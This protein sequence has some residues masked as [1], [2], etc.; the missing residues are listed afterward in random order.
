MASI[1]DSPDF[2]YLHVHSRKTVIYLCTRFIQVKKLQ[3]LSYK[4]NPVIKN[5]QI[6]S[7]TPALD[8]A[9]GLEW[10]AATVPMKSC[11]LFLFVSRQIL[12]HFI[13][14]EQHVTFLFFRQISK[15][16]I[17]REKIIGRVNENWV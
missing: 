12:Y 10:G 3:D 4:I 16:A 5:C 17:N 9:A 8:K 11:C 15:I 1:E 14:F 13:Q 6:L 7:S 2:K